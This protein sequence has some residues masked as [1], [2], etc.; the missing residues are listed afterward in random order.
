VRLSGR[1][2]PSP[3]GSPIPSATSSSTAP[4]FP[5]ALV[6]TIPRLYDDNVRQGFFTL[7]DAEVLLAHV[8]HP[9]IRDFIIA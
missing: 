8:A 3:W 9:G 2:A 7:A 5:Q 1:G 4:L 6:A